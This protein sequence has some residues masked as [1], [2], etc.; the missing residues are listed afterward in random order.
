MAWAIGGNSAVQGDF[1]IATCDCCNPCDYPLLDVT[2]TWTDLDVTK[3]YL[4]YTFTNG[5]TIAICPDL[6]G[7]GNSSG[8]ITGT[9]TDYNTFNILEK[10]KKTGTSYDTPGFVS[11]KKF[12]EWMST[13]TFTVTNDFSGISLSNGSYE[14]WSYSAADIRK[15]VRKKLKV[16]RG[17]TEP[18]TTYHAYNFSYLLKDPPPSGIFHYFTGYGTGNDGTNTV[19]LTTF[20]DGINSS[21]EGSVTSASGLTI[22]WAKNNA[23]VPWGDCF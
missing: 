16:R 22:T 19:T 12:R 4:G 1:G 10:W 23:G 5:Q 7:C 17:G 2:L 20:N 3:N 14:L 15:D 18:V 21:M 13:Q 11:K 8:T 6:Y 9:F